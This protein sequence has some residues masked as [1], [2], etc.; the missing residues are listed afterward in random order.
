MNLHPYIHARQSDD[1]VNMISKIFL[2]VVFISGSS[3][4]RPQKYLAIFLI[5]VRDNVMIFKCNKI[6]AD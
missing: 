1:F 3:I 6:E 4:I 5:V 2:A